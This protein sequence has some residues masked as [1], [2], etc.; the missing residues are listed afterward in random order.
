MRLCIQ[1]VLGLIGWTALAG[2][3]PSASRITPIATSHV[4][5][6][7]PAVGLQLANGYT[8]TRY[9]TN[10]LGPSALAWGPAPDPLTKGPRRLYIAQM[11]GAENAGTGQILA[12]AEPNAAPVVI[13]SNLQKPTGLTWLNNALYVVAYRS[14]LRLTDSDADGTLDRTETLVADVPFN[15]RSLGQV[16]VG[17]DGR[18]YFESTGGSPTNSGYLYS[19]N[20]DG[21]D[22]RIAARGLKN[23]YAYAFNPSGELYMTEI[24]DALLN[25]PREEINRWVA[26]ADYGWDRCPAELQAQD[27]SAAACQNVPKPIATFPT[28]ASPTGLA[29]FADGLLVA[30]WGPVEPAVVWVNPYTGEVKPFA[31]GLQFPMD[32]LPVDDQSVLVLDFA[33]TLYQITMSK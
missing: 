20:P 7:T 19:I 5:A 4:A 2:C 33:G 24:G 22:Q 29:W 9:A 21:T 17:P 12:F 31:S 6:D 23:A 14:L 27:P 1:I 32:V 3:A 25:P 11:N 26:D 10:L 15:G 28:H 18:L 13:A 16:D 30:K 8:A